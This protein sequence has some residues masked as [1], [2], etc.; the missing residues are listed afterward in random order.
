MPKFKYEYNETFVDYIL[1]KCC[2]RDPTELRRPLLY[3]HVHEY[4][5]ADV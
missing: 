1:E 4:D 2:Q 3:L 5:Y